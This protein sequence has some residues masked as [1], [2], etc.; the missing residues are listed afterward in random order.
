VKPGRT[1]LALKEKRRSK[2]LRRGF[3]RVSLSWFYPEGDDNGDDDDK[4]FLAG[5]KQV[6]E[7]AKEFAEAYLIGVAAHLDDLVTP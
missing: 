7:Q 6:A 3:I 5:L 2:T 1:E 4:A